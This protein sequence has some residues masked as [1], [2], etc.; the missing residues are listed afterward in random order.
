MRMSNSF[1]GLTEKKINV[2]AMPLYDQ[3][4]FKHISV[5][6]IYLGYSHVLKKS[7]PGYMRRRD[8]RVI[9]QRDVR[10]DA[11]Q[12]GLWAATLTVWATVQR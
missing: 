2:L 3:L 6:R 11:Q 8:A 10:V 5:S 9:Y 7:L 1:N 4:T 12:N